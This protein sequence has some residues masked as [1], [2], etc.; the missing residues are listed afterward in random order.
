MNSRDNTKHDSFPA[1]RW[2]LVSAARSDDEGKARR[3]IGE[4]CETYWFPIY[5]YIRNQGHEPHD[6]EDFTQSFFQSILQRNSLAGTEE[7]RGKLRSYLLASVKKFLIDAH[8]KESSQRRGGNTQTVPLDFSSAE[9]LY[10]VS[11][12]NGTTTSETAG[13]FDREWANII[14][15]RVLGNL[16]MGIGDPRKL[17]LFDALVPYLTGT[18]GDPPYRELGETFSVKTATMRVTMMRTR[19]RFRN[20]LEKE[21]VDTIANE[22]ELRDEVISLYRRGALSSPRSPKAGSRLA[23]TRSVGGRGGQFQHSL[24]GSARVGRC[25]ANWHRT[26]PARGAAMHP[27]PPR[28]YMS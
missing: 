2:S 10:A 12:Q 18:A 4:L 14:I 27:D 23:A 24:L 7:S 11:G 20:A 22:D 3:A 19:K 17:A 13:H 1:T 16:R 5:S 21:I 8:R 6:A 26:S 28:S 9:T 15:A 25:D